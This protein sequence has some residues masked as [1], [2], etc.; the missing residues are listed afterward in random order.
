MDFTSYDEIWESFLEN[1]KTDKMNL[2]T[3]SDRIYAMI[4]NAVK[5]YN[6]RMGTKYVCDDIMENINDKL[7]DDELII[8]AHYIK[9]IFL[10][11]D[12]NDY[13]TI[14]GSFT[15]EVGQTNYSTILKGKENAV[16]EEEEEIEKL[17]YNTVDDWEV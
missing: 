15:K 9:L 16:K 13:I 7:S 4:K 10:R 6:N 2:P 11:N 5:H 8:L 14:W 3:T 17:I 1:C 12:K